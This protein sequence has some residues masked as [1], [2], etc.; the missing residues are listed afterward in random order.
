MKEGRARSKLMV[1]MKKRK[2][3]KKRTKEKVSAPLWV[4]MVQPRK[5]KKKTLKKSLVKTS[6]NVK[7]LVASWQH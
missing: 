3:R 4:Q 5:R 2:A 6:L 1:A 7:V